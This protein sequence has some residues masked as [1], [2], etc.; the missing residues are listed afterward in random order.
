[1]L[2]LN[3][4]TKGFDCH[5]YP[6]IWRNGISPNS[7]RIDIANHKRFSTSTRWV[8]KRIKQY[9]TNQAYNRCS[10]KHPYMCDPKYKNLGIYGIPRRGSV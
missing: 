6:Y 4:I 8:W 7:H 2:L 9:P 10:F 3:R 1:M 5:F